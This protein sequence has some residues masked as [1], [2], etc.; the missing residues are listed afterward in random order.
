MSIP[1]DEAEKIEQD[2]LAAERKRNE[3]I[4]QKRRKQGLAVPGEI[5]TREEQATRMWAFLYVL[6]HSLAVLARITDSLSQR[7]YKPTDSDLEDDD[8]DE[9]EDDADDPSSWFEDEDG[10]KGQDIVDP[11]EADDI[12]NIIRVDE[13]RLPLDVRYREHT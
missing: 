4:L 2:T 10:R 13:S 8:E 12:S 5:L 11:D 3:A 7:N 9:D 6:P 1:F